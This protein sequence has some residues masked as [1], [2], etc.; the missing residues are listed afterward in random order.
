MFNANGV[1]EGWAVMVKTRAD[2]N[3]GDG[4]FWYE[5]TD[6]EDRSHLVAAGNGVSL[7]Y[8]CHAGG[9]DFVLTE[10]PLK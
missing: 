10:Y 7:C 1:L 3:G 8:S 2:S 9:N 4:W 6:I 5:T